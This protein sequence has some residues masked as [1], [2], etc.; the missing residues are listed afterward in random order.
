MFLSKVHN[1]LLTLDE[2]ARQYRLGF[3]SWNE[4]EEV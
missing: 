1:K 2:I 3:S 4:F